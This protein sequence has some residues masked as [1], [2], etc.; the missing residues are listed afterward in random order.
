MDGIIK[1][2]MRIDENVKAI[3]EQVVEEDDGEAEED[4]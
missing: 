3:R 4:Q 2:L 1:L